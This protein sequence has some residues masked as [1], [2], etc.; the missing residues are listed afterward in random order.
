M[1]PLDDKNRRLDVLFYVLILVSLV[2]FG[3][4]LSK[5]LMPDRA[6]RD[7]S[8][9]LSETEGRIAFDAAA[10]EKLVIDPFPRVKETPVHLVVFMDPEKD[11][12]VCLYELQEWVGP[13]AKT[14]VYG[15]TLFVPE[16][17]SRD[18]LQGIMK[19]HALMAENFAYFSRE[20]RLAGFH[21]LGV[22]KVVLNQT[23][24]ILWFQ[25]GSRY[26]MEYRAFAE[27]LEAEIRSF[28]PNFEN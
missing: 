19:E 28:E 1:L 17:V 9:L 20:S 4:R 14:S 8:A 3:Y 23:R 26:E 27:K 13:L 25:K 11:C 22:F 12:P 24:G 6:A 2:I 10:F 21:N 15:L 5:T 18:I 16:D 7:H